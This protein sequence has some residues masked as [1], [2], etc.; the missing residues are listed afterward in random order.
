ML[1]ALLQCYTSQLS[2]QEGTGGESF[3]SA[4]KQSKDRKES[5]TLGTQISHYFIG[6]FSTTIIARCSSSSCSGSLAASTSSSTF[7]SK[8]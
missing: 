6:S 7:A 4:R 2:G 3:R 5:K 8:C 1:A